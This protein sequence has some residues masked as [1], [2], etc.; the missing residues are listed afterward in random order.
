MSGHWSQRNE[1]GGRFA[2]WLIRSIG[3]KFG[4]RF[5]RGLLYPITLYF[6]LRRGPER[7]ASRRFLAR[8]L[9]RKAT[10]WMVLR[11]I[12]CYAATIL[13]R[14]FLLAHSTRRFDIRTE[15]LQHLHA[16]MDAGQGVLLLGAHFGSF[17]ALRALADDR[18]QAIVRTVMDRQQTAAMTELLH[19]LNPQA[20]ASVIDV[21][22]DAMSSVLA[23]GESAREGALIGFLGDRARPGEKTCDARF[24]GEAAAFPVAPYLIASTLQ[25]PVML[26]FSVYRGANRYDLY[27]EEFA[28]ALHIQ[29]ERRSAELSVW[30]GRYVKRLE[31]YVRLSPYN[32][33]NF[34]DFWDHPA[35][36]R[37]VA[38]RADRQTCA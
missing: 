8:V 24:F 3:L 26:C 1:G 15:G 17:E 32:W 18:P 2:L 7:R 23:I 30:V 19:A 28:D 29:R 35:D 13:D 6:F 5:A 22:E 36:R 14:I 10:T 33:F 37:I 34:Y 21:G 9:G 27:F 25:L 12:H 31:H 4:R 16:H 20:A 11:H 38:R